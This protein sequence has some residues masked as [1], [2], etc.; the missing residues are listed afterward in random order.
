MRSIRTLDQV[1]DFMSKEIHSLTTC[2]AVADPGFPVG[3]RQL[4]PEAATF[5]KICMSKRKNLDPW[6]ARPGG[7]PWIRQCNATVPLADNVFT[8][9]N[10]DENKTYLHQQASNRTSKTMPLL[11]GYVNTK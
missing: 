11:E 1:H 6:G 3:G 8:A 2:N 5:R 7:A 4:L 9:E 10:N